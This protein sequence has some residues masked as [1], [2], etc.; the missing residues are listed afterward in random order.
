M[1]TP[2]GDPDTGATKPICMFLA[3]GEGACGI[4][5]IAATAATITIKITIIASIFFCKYTSLAFFFSISKQTANK[6]N[7]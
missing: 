4:N 5:S 3:S 7:S 2:T 6:I 1:S